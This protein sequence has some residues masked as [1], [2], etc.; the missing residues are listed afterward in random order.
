MLKFLNWIAKRKWNQQTKS[1][2]G[3]RTGYLPHLEF[4]ERRLMP[5]GPVLTMTQGVVSVTPASGTFTPSPPAPVNFLTPGTTSTDTGAG[6]WNP[7]TPISS[8]STPTI[9]SDLIG[10]IPAGTLIK[11]AVEIINTGDTPASNVTISDTFDT[12]GFEKPTNALGYNLVVT[13]GSGAGPGALSSV[14]YTPSAN[15][16]SF[17]TSTGIR[18]LDNPGDTSSNGGAV[19]AT[20]NALNQNV[21]IITFDLQ[22]TTVLTP[23]TRY[24]STSTISDYTSGQT[25]PNLAIPPI[26]ASAVVN[27]IADLSINKTVGNP[28]PNVGDTVTFTITASNAGPDRAFNAQVNDILPA[29]LLYVSSNPSVGSYN[30]TNGV[31]TIGTMPSPATDTL[32]I[33]AIVLAPTQTGAPPAPSTNTATIF[34]DDL[35]PNST[36]PSSSATVTPLYADLAILKTVSNP[37]P[38]QGTQIVY[39]LTVTNLGPD[40]SQ[41]V[42]VMDALRTGISYVSSSATQGSYISGL[43]TIGNLA[44]GKTVTLTIVG[45]VTSLGP[46]ANVATVNAG[47][48]NPR[49]N[50]NTSE[51]DLVTLSPTPSKRSL[52]H[53][54]QDSNGNHTSNQSR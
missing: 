32:T 39:K 15:P 10:S 36:P 12:T 19:K 13:Y 17:F 52:I 8:S 23:G 7:Q 18:I 38:L 46:I 47:T 54:H 40:V 48:Y 6:Q 29:G 3:K 35:P 37:R 25:G 33:M 2:F 45:L 5:A 28:T 53:H 42:T 24:P 11:F 20:P 50:K 27:P 4:L 14:R 41:A 51:A 21:L 30:S 31:W 1:S 9:N 44:S 43:W 49:L 22:T 16:D 34:A 26:T